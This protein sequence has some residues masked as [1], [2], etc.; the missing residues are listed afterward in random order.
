ML[1]I[2][3][4]NGKTL[5]EVFIIRRYE[6]KRGTMAGSICNVVRSVKTVKKQEVINEYQVWIYADGTTTCDCPASGDCCHKDET[7]FSEMRRCN[8]IAPVRKPAVT[9]AP[10]RELRNVTNHGDILPQ[11]RDENGKWQHFK[12][13]EGHD[14]RFL[15][16][17]EDLADKFIAIDSNEHR[18]DVWAELQ[19]MIADA[20]AEYEAKEA[21][22]AAQTRR[23]VSPLNGPRGFQICKSWKEIEAERS[24]K[25]EVA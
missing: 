8:N 7:S 4:K 6:I 15:G 14:I 23:I 24:A 2:T 1:T 12:N 21:R 9:P 22:K 16:G 11:Y 3:N 20:N 25:K 13:K 19:Q 10:V 5:K 17:L 18:A